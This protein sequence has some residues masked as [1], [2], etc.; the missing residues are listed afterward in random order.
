MKPGDSLF[1]LSALPGFSWTPNTFSHVYL[2]AG[3]AG[4][5][6]IYQLVQGILD[7]PIDKT[8]VSVIFGVNTEEDLLLRSEFDDYKR[9]YPDRFEIHY[10]VSRPGRNFTPNEGVRLGKVTKGLLSELMGGSKEQ[11]AKIFVCGPPAMET[12]L[13]GSRASGQ[14]I[15]EQLGYSKD[16]IHRF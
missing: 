10:T 4:I 1:I 12:S 14:G 6:P 15:L 13:V 8:K 9:R 7:N 11:N 5:T 2:I 16:E 3:G